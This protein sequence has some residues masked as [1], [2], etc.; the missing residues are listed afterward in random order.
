MQFRE[1]PVPTT[2]DRTAFYN[3]TDVMQSLGLRERQFDSIVMHCS[4][5]GKFQKYAVFLA[6]KPEPS[7]KAKCAY[8]QQEQERQQQQEQERQQQQ[9]Q[10]QQEQQQ[11]QQQQAM[12]VYYDAIRSKF[13]SDAMYY[14]YEFDASMHINGAISAHIANEKFKFYILHDRQ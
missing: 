5:A 3:V 6:A 2:N 4:G 14:N 13:W 1:Q 12:F 7:A 10:E 9:Q 11:Q 8:Q